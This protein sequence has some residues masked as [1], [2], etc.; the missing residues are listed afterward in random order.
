MS[1]NCVVTTCNRFAITN[2][3]IDKPNNARNVNVRSDRPYCRR[4]L[5]VPITTPRPTPSKEPK[6]MSLTLTQMR[7]PISSPTLPPRGD[8]PQFH[9][10]KIELDQVTQRSLMGT[11]SLKFR[12]LR[13]FSM[14]TG[15]MGG[16]DISYNDLGLS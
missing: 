14:E 10:N 8:C 16:L 4:A 9:S 7:R 6:V 11:L 2:D 1:L 13:L 3:G 12:D 15:S 5:Q